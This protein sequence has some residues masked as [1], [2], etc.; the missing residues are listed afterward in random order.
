MKYG[1]EGLNFNGNEIL[2]LKQNL[3][4]ILCMDINA[5]HILL[6]SDKRKMCKVKVLDLNGVNIL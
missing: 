5:G 6:N 2:I 4:H 3:T 1:M